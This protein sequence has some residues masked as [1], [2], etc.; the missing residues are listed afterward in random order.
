M[1]KLP[2]Y[3]ST[4][5]LDGVTYIVD[6][7]VVEKRIDGTTVIRDPATLI[8]YDPTTGEPVPDSVFDTGYA[9]SRK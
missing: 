5:T 9:P 8:A 7:R 3:M 4:E 1:A 6:R 2:E